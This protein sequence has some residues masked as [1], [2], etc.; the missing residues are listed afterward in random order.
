MINVAV[1]DHLESRRAAL[2]SI[3]REFEEKTITKLRFSSSVQI[4]NHQFNKYRLW[5][6][7]Y[8]T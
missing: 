6:C 1:V 8:R 7:A 4:L 3:L 2:V 5:S